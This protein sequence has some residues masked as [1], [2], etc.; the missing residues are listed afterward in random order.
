VGVAALDAGAVAVVSAAGAQLLAQ[1]FQVPSGVAAWSDQGWGD[2]AFGP[3]PR[4]GAAADA[5]CCGCRAGGLKRRGCV[6]FWHGE[7]I[8]RFRARFTSEMT[9]RAIST[10]V[11]F[12]TLGGAPA[13]GGWAAFFLGEDAA[14]QLVQPLGFGDELG[15]AVVGDVGG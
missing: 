4:K 2:D 11:T 5:E 1:V 8:A 3:P 7:T 6:S 13:L 14:G 12:A 15:A 9:D 10:V